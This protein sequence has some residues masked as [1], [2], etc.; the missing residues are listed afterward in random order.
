MGGANLCWG[1]HGARLCLPNLNICIERSLRC[2]LWSD[3]LN[4]I[5]LIRMHFH[6]VVT[7]LSP[8]LSFAAHSVIVK[9]RLHLDS[10]HRV[11]RRMTGFHEFITFSAQ[12]T[13]KSDPDRTRGTAG[14]PPKKVKK[15]VPHLWC[16]SGARKRGRGT[17]GTTKEF[18]VNKR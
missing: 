11:D 9:L 4:S 3:C 16:G 1:G 17:C 13:R 10:C 12:N 14:T 15:R 8:R 18:K 2:C 6:E 5:D 7:K